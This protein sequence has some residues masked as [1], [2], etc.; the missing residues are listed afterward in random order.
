MVVCVVLRVRGSCFFIH[1][2]VGVFYSICLDMFVYNS[3]YICVA[4]CVCV[5]VCV[6]V[7][8]SMKRRSKLQVITQKL[9]ATCHN[10]I[11]ILA[12]W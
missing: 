2:R 7:S 12:P 1:V 5:C 9:V 10:L 4:V 6:Y 11:F 3:A 8:E